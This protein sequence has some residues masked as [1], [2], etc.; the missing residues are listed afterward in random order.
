MRIKQ[1]LGSL[2]I[3]AAFAAGAL[4]VP[5]ADNP[6]TEAF[7]G[8]V[9]ETMNAAT[10]TYANVETAKGKKWVAAPEFPVKVGDTLSVTKAMAMPKYHSK[11]LNRDFDIVYFTG[12]VTVNGKPAGPAAAAP[13]QAQELPKG[14]PPLT[15]AAAKSAIDFSNVK[16]PAGG[17]TVSE[18]VVDKDKLRGK[19]VTFRGKVVKYNEAVLGKNWLH[20]R[21]GSGAEGSNDLTVTTSTAAKLGD[22]VLVTGKVAT[23]RDFG[24][25]YKYAVIVEDAKVTVE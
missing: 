21:D 16:K 12:S 14:H 13:A 11:T 20:V 19:E 9:L 3:V 8:K 17:K 25:G 2:I 22:T 18:V 1:L 6:E 15:G 4:S 5:A 23:N 24:G 7:S 10:Y